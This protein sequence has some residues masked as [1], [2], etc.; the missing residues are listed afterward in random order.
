[1]QIWTAPE[2]SRFL[3][4]V[5]GDRLAGAW[6]LLATTGMRRG[7]ALDLRWQHV[8]LDAGRLSIYRTLITT[9]VQRKDEPGMAWGTPK[10]ARVAALV[11]GNAE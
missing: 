6:W 5:A 4:G 2:L 8:D 1:M 10:T 3:A 7:E 11:T 9:D